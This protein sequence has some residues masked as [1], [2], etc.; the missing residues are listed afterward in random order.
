MCNPGVLARAQ[1]RGIKYDGQAK[2]GRGPQ[3]AKNAK[4][5]PVRFSRST[6]GALL[7]AVG[8]CKAPAGPN[9]ILIVVDTLRPDHLGYYGYSRNT[10]P[11]IDQF[12]AD[13]L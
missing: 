3:S 8:L 5:W 6:S 11:N 10:S 13:S 4:I 7:L 12:A 9:V 1:S 2:L